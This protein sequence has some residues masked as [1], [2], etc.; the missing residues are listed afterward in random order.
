MAEASGLL[1]QSRRDARGTSVA[2]VQSKGPV[3]ETHHLVVSLS[4]RW[5]VLSEKFKVDVEAVVGV[6]S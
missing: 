3:S 1:A 5:A 4:T 6:C 2:L